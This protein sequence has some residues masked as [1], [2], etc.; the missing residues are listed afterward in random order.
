MPGQHQVEHDRVVLGRT[1]HPEGVLA[2]EGQVRG[3]PLLP[4]PLAE[5]SGHLGLVL[6][7]QHTHIGPRRLSREDERE[8]TAEPALAF[9]DVAAEEDE[10]GRRQRR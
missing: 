8:M 4:Q 1:G 5:Q 7:D 2:L 10:G 9:G 3:K 6:D